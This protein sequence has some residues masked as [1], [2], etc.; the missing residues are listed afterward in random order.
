MDKKTPQEMEFQAWGL[1]KIAVRNIVVFFIL[2][3]LAGISI[4]GK[5]II[6][7][8]QEKQALFDELIK[9]K[10]K[11]ALKIEELKNENLQTVL[12]LN[13]VSQNQGDIKEELKETRKSLNAIN[14]KVRQ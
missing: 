12:K 10:D 4:L 13:E 1:S 14:K 2:T 5:T 9:C 8:N 11:G 3:L 6:V 7:L